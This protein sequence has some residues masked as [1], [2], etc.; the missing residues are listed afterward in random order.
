MKKIMSILIV[1]VVGI[2]VLCGF[3]TAT[4][5]S[6]KITVD[7][8]PPGEPWITG[9]IEVLVVGILILNRLEIDTNI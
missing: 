4:V 1:L 3:G 7:N 9:P 8:H 2:L 5:T 6:N